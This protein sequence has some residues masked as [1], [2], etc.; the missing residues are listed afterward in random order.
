MR[1]VGF[2]ALIMISALGALLFGA[3]LVFLLLI[4]LTSGGNYTLTRADG[5]PIFSVSVFPDDD[6]LRAMILLFGLPLAFLIT[7][8][9]LIKYSF[10]QLTLNKLP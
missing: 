1:Q 6:W 3:W 5:W 7:S 8:V 2:F 10:R 9:K 4:L